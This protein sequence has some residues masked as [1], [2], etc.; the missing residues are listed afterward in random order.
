MYAIAIRFRLGRRHLAEKQIGGSR[1]WRP[2]HMIDYHTAGL[3]HERVTRCLLLEEPPAD[4]R[5]LGEPEHPILPP[6]SWVM[7]ELGSFSLHLWR[8]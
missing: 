6:T 5:G 1:G 4:T 3:S 2:T 8:I 7:C